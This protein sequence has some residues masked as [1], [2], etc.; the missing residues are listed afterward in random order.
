MVP[1]SPIWAPIIPY[2]PYSPGCFL[3]FLNFQTI[4]VPVV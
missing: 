3:M 4:Y 2:C 1:Y